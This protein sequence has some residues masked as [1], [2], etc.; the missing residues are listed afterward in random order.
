V[1]DVHGRLLQVIYAFECA[2]WNDDD[3]IHISVGEYVYNRWP[4]T[5]Y[6]E[7]DLDFYGSV[8]EAPVTCLPSGS[9]GVVVRVDEW[10]G[11]VEVL[12]DD[13]RYAVRSTTTVEPH[14]LIRKDA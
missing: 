6:A 10:Q 13:L 9:F 8:R 4:I 7:P 1:A 3:R 2:V 5:L 11:E 14:E 12:W